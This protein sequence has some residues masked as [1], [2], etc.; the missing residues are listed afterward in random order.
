MK[1]G[2][3]PAVKES[4]PN[5][6]EFSFELNLIKCI[7]I[8]FKNAEIKI[9]NNKKDQ[10]NVDL[11]I[12]SGG[13]DLVKF[14]KNKKNKIREEITKYFYSKGIN[15]NIPILGICYGAQFIAEHFNCKLEMK[16]H[17]NNHYIKLN[18]F[19]KQ[20]KILVNS[21]HNYVITK[22]GK[23][24]VNLA[25]AND[26]TIECFKHKRR[27]I[28]GLMWHPERNRKISK[29]DIKIIKSILCN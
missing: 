12:I 3:I 21:F 17:I 11:L 9:L 14:K 18:Y 5:Q 23:D 2:I 7:N 1:I 27:K 24:L 29:I 20:K 26:D 25:Q 8:I 28:L 22:L 4:Y 15:K 16:K 13:N 19:K 10:F 6:H